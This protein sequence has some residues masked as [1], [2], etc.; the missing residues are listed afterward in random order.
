ML[1]LQ[2]WI[3]W[4]VEINTCG[5]EGSGQREKPSC[6]ADTTTQLQPTPWELWSQN[7]SSELYQTGENTSQTGMKC[8]DFTPLQSSVTRNGLPWEWA[9]HWQGGSS[10]VRRS[11]KRLRAEGFVRTALPANGATEE[12]KNKHWGLSVYSSASPLP[13]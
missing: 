13:S 8:Q 4:E 2:G 5:R 1:G 11:P 10:Q 3:P 12:P 9:C 6:D 7:G